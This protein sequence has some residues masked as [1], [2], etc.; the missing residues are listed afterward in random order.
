MRATW[1]RF[2]LLDI[3]ILIASV[4]VGMALANHFGRVDTP[5]RG[6]PTAVV[7]ALKSTICGGMFAGPAILIGQFLRGR[8]ALLGVGEWLWLCPWSVVVIALSTGPGFIP[9]ILFLLGGFSAVAFLYLLSY[10]VRP[11]ARVA[12]R[13]TDFFG[14][15]TCILTGSFIIYAVLAPSI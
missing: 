2:T 9:P 11:K 8:R 7:W 15:L 10:L 13:W 14:S 12:C 4:A 6:I 1:D 3:G 5:I